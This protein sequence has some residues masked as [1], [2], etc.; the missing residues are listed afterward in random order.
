MARPGKAVILYRYI[1]TYKAPGQ[2]SQYSDWLRAG[3][4]RGRGSSTGR[5]KNFVH[6]VQDGYGVHPTSYSMVTGALSPGVKRPGHE[7]D[8]SPTASV[9]VKNVS[10]YTS[11]PPYAFMV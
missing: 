3:R 10:I 7:V 8:H 11:T 6:V 2:R 9:E 5:V 1:H 4:P